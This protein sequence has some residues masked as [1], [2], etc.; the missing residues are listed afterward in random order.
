MTFQMQC[1]CYIYLDVVYL[2]AQQKLC[3]QKAKTL[4]FGMEGIECILVSRFRLAKPNCV[5]L[6][7][8]IKNIISIIYDS[9]LIDVLY[10]NISY[11]MMNLIVLF[12][13]FNINTFYINLIKLKVLEI[14]PFWTEGGSVSISSVAFIGNRDR[15]S[16][17]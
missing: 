12:S 3:I 14:H 17:T 15:E 13:T 4:K 1:F 6:T 11:Y 10:K 8:F 5:T 2:N 16:P 9:K 7:K